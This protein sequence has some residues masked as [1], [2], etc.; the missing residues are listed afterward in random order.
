MTK[1][2]LLYRAKLSIS[3]CLFVLF[4]QRG[5]A[6]YDVTAVN[7]GV[8]TLKSLGNENELGAGFRIEYAPN[9]FTTYMGEFNRF[10]AIGSDLSE[11]YSSI[12][13]GVNLIMFNWY[14]TTITGGMSYVGNN[15]AP[16]DEVE[17]DAFLALGDE[18]FIHGAQLKMR[19]LHRLSAP[20]HIFAELN[21]QSLGTRY[22]NFLIGISYD[23]GAR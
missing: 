12:A 2:A 1:V 17:K 8:V 21:L 23:F 11:G 14:P 9:C 16:I 10:F 19:A 7:Y 18:N 5:L 22:H 3:I 6:Q 4:A 20:V 13:F 15:S